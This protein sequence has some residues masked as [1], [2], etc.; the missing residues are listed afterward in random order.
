MLP[1]YAT[2]RAGSA[3]DCNGQA[4]KRNISGAVFH[5][6]INLQIKCIWI[7][8][9]CLTLCNYYR[10]QFVCRANDARYTQK[11]GGLLVESPILSGLIQ[12]WNVST[13]FSE[14][15]PYQIWWKSAQPFSSCYMR[16]D[17]HIH[18][19]DAGHKRIFDSCRY[20]RATN[21]DLHPRPQPNRTHDTCATLY[22]I[23]HIEYAQDEPCIQ[24]PWPG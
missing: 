23:P 6:F 7:Y 24:A 22:P 21:T 17:G 3:C 15:S 9:V 2:A 4:R 5:C 11:R 18:T 20:E 12:N 14:I 19:Q 13:N 8:N 16:T 10:K 1:P